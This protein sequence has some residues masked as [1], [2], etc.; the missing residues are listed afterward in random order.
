M[1]K[2]LFIVAA[3]M[4]LISSCSSDSSDNNIELRASCN[5]GV[6]NGTE[7]GPDCGGDCSP[8][9]TCDDGVMNGN[10][11]GV[12]CG[13]SCAECPVVVSIPESGFES[14]QSYEGYNLLWSDEFNGSSLDEEKWGFHLG[15]G[16][17]NL[18]WWGNNELQNF[19]DR[20]DNIYFKD[21]N[22]IIEAKNEDIEG[23]DYSSSRIHTDDKF[24]FRYGRVDV[25]ASM[26]SV[27]G[28]WVAFF[29]LNKNYSI[30]DPAAYWPSGGEID[31]MEYLG[32][33]PTEILGTGHYGTDFPNNHR[34][35]SVFFDALNDQN[36]DEVY[37]VFSI[38][39]EEDKIT[40]LVNDVEYHTMT[41][42]TTASN[43][44]P[45]PFNDEFYFIFALSVGGNLPSA[46]PL[47]EDFPAFL[48][49]DYIRV[50]QRQ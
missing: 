31:I 24:E 47:P 19:T 34:F 23:M 48:V 50:F 43:G 30:E 40:W 11:T 28:T 4:A 35:N 33:D 10:E 16:C 41:P 20:A 36:F 32:E 39:W 22:L 27:A 9:P 17:P 49:V 29:M 13:G 3:F 1:K 14:P 38:I 18:C 37:Y 21:G 8:C 45:Y 12:D 42:D 25:R 6:Q 5:D 46:T 44:Q 7:T 15:N 2:T 26:P